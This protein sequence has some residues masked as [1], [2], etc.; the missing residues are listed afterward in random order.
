MDNFV[1]GLAAEDSRDL[2]T[3]S[4]QYQADLTTGI[5]DECPRDG[6][7]LRVTYLHGIAFIVVSGRRGHPRRQQTLSVGQDGIAGTRINLQCAHNTPSESNPSFPMGKNIFAGLK[8]RTAS[9]AFEHLMHNIPSMTIGDYC[10]H[11]GGH[12]NARRVHFRS[13]APCARRS[14]GTPCI[15]LD[16][17]GNFVD[18]RNVDRFGVHLRIACVE[19]VDVT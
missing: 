14:T 11:A 18:Q 1:V 12:S 10:G 7:A 6:I 17:R 2:M 9:R 8:E 16:G 5:I 15:V 3:L 4:P 13:H 19:S